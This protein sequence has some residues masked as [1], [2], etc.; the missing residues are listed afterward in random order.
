MPLAG[1]VNHDSISQDFEY[2]VFTAYIPKGIHIVGSQLGKIPLLKNNNFNLG[3]QKNY[4]T[5]SPHHYLT[6]TTRKKP[7]LV[8]KP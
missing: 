8:S 7:H 2:F 4:T 1:D 6:K 5:L 3:D